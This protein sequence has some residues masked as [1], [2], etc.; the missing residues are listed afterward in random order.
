M[1]CPDC[2]LEYDPKDGMVHDE[3]RCYDCT[4]KE[5]NRIP[6][7]LGG[8]SEEVPVPTGPNYITVK[9][10]KSILAVLDPIKG[11]TG[12][13]AVLTLR[14]SDTGIS[15]VM[16]D[17]GRT[18]GIEVSVGLDGDSIVAHGL[19]RDSISV[20][21]D[22][23]IDAIKTF[24]EE[25][26]TISFERSSLVIQ[27][28]YARRVMPLITQID[29]KMELHLS[30]VDEDEAVYVSM[31]KLKR[32]LPAEKVEEVIRVTLDDGKATFMADDGS[33]RNTYSVFVDLMHMSFERVTSSYGLDM[34]K[35]IVTKMHLKDD[36]MVRMGIMGNGPCMLSWEQREASFEVLMAPRLEV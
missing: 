24:G 28:E 21:L 23:L 7:E 9:E 31:G 6:E 13:D 22:D 11:V 27:S 25:Q 16:Y 19:Q 30:S 32:L 33:G 36:D 12:K 20:D 8:T 26:V 17:N 5:R 18:Q 1:R 14:T 2:G 3:D 35:E 29:T 15:T 10:A 34:L 4:M